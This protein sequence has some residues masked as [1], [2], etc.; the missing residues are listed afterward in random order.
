MDLHGL[1]YGSVSSL[2]Q[3]F[4]RNKRKKILKV[5]INNLVSEDKIISI[6]HQG[7]L[8]SW[9][10]LEGNSSRIIPLGQIRDPHQ[11]IIKEE[12]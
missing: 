11:I 10:F 4:I 2:Y 9:T 3:I 6:W 12:T 1:V 7:D 8:L 5:E